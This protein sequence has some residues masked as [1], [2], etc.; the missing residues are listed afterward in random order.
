MIEGRAGLTGLDDAVQNWESG[1]ELIMQRVTFYRNFGSYYTGAL[2]VFNA[3]PL[4]ILSTNTDFVHNVS[5]HDIAAV[6]VAFFS[7]W[8][9]Y[10][11]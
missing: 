3:W 9:R 8:Q 7:R 1:I 10:R 5:S 11:C 2:A 6:W 4:S